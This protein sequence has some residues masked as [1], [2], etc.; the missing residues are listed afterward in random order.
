LGNAEGP[1]DAP[2]VLQDS[3]NLSPVSFRNIWVKPL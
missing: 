1:G 2:L 3:P